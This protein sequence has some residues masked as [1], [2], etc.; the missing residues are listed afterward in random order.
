MSLIQTAQTTQ[1]TPAASELDTLHINLWGLPGTNKREVAGQLYGRLSGLGVSTALVHDYTKELGWAGELARLDED[2]ELVEMDQ[3]IISAEQFRREELVHG[4]IR[5]AVT[6][7]PV[8][9]GV[10]YAQEDDEELLRALL[11]RR[12]SGWRNLDVLLEREIPLSYESMGRIQ[13]REEALAMYPRLMGL[14]EQ[15]RPGFLRLSADDAVEAITA[16]V[17]QDLG[18]KVT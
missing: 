15:E 7:A 16:L 9:A 10:L 13:S 5:V 12:T 8:L 6:E 2:G 18:L 4:R 11:R 17:M 3:F 1:V 14:I